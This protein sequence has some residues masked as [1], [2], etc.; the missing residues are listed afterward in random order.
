MMVE[1]I[2]LPTG[3]L[4]LSMSLLIISFIISTWLAG[5]I[6]RTG[7]LMYNKKANYKELWKWLVLNSL[8]PNPLSYL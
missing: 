7:I 3:E 2:W 6:Y 1:F 8:V 5:R 4:I